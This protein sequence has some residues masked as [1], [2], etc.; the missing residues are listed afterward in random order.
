MSKFQAYLTRAKRIPWI[1]HV[2]RMQ[3]RFGSRLGNQFA[4][5]ITYFSVLAMVPLLMVTFAT[6]GFVLTVARPDLLVLVDE[7]ITEQ[8]SGMGAD[9]QAMISGIVRSF[10]VN[11]GAIGI[12]GLLS[13]VYSASG[14]AGNLKSAIRAQ[15]RAQFDLAE[16]KRNMVVETLVNVALMLGLLVLIPATLALA[17]VSTT[18]TDEL[19]RL[20]GALAVPGVGAALRVVGILASTA[21]GW[22]LFL[23][24]LTVFPEESF[25]FRVKWRAA[26]IGSVGLGLLEFLTSFL[27]ASFTSNPAAALFGPVIILMLF[28]NLFAR[29]ILSVAAWMATAVQQANPLRVQDIDAP[30]AVVPGSGV[31]ADQVAALQ[32]GPSP[33]GAPPAEAPGEGAGLAPLGP[34]AAGEA[35]RTAAAMTPPPGTAQVS[36]GMAVRN[37]RV[38]MR[39]GW[40]TGTLTGVGLG[41]VLVALGR[42]LGRRR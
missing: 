24:V 37:A 1:A 41:T 28:L 16:K 42:A 32:A 23:Y 5:A 21:A 20:L 2:L 13:G 18:L 27:V 35:A 29:L 9:L 38:A 3:D 6:I 15:T 26:L 40:I 7:M 10:L 33:E 31:T 19:L 36:R 34:G 30:L 17:N 12:I 39:T 22:V 11:W 14:W 25:A 4:G 8:L